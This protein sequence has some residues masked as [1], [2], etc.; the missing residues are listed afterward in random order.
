VEEEDRERKKIEMKEPIKNS[1]PR[2]EINTGICIITKSSKGLIFRH[3]LEVA[4]AA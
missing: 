1:C 3:Y 4:L 2:D